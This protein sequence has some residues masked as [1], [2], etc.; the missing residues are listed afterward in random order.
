MATSYIV[1]SENGNRSECTWIALRNDE[2]V[3][4][5]IL[6]DSKGSQLPCEG[7]SFSA[8]LHSQME[9]DAATHTHH[10][11]KRVDG[12]HP[13]FMNIDSK[14]MGVGGDVA[15]FPCVYPPFLLKPDDEVM[16]SFWLLPLSAD[17][18]PA[19]MREKY[20]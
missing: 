9:L 2:Q 12:K 3:G 4:I 13:I 7:L 11:E 1:P 20:I 17:Q 16:T 19:L 6:N 8:Q 10:L 14:Q 15:W 5:L 18:D